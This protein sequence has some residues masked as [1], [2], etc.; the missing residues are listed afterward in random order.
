LLWSSDIWHPFLSLVVE[1]EALTI[2]DVTGI[3][4]ADIS[5]R[6]IVELWS[7]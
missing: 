4:L 5:S 6:Y 2:R 3:T 1:H 7:T